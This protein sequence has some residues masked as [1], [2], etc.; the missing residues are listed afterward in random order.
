L[1]RRRILNDRCRPAFAFMQPDLAIGLDSRL[2]I[3]DPREAYNQDWPSEGCDGFVGRLCRMTQYWP[4]EP[5]RNIPAS[6]ALTPRPRLMTW[7]CLPSLES[8]PFMSAPWVSGQQQPSVKGRLLFTGISRTNVER[9]HSHWG[10]HRQPHSRRIALSMMAGS[11][12]HQERNSSREREE[13]NF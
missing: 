10:W 3:C 6:V 11:G 7:P 2:L 1:D 8:R 4:S 9:L 13:S 5:E 12:R